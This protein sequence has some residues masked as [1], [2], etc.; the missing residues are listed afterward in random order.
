MSFTPLLAGISIAASVAAGACSGEGITENGEASGIATIQFSGALDTL[1]TGMAT[2]SVFPSVDTPIFVRIK[3]QDTTLRAPGETTV[4]ADFSSVDTSRHGVVLHT[5]IG[6]HIVIDMSTE[7]VGA[8]IIERRDDRLR[9]TI[10]FEDIAKV[11]VDS[12]SVANLP[13]SVATTF[14][15]N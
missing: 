9:G 14:D 10:L 12:D 1:M 7:S 11:A 2:F 4:F 8:N 5:T 15:A 13:L 6:R 3:S